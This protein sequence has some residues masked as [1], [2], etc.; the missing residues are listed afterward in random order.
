MLLEQVKIYNNMSDKGIKLEK[1]NFTIEVKYSEKA[2]KDKLIKLTVTK[3]NEIVLS[4][5]EIISMLVGQVNS[6]VLSAAF[7]ET[8][9]VNVVEVMRQLQC[10]LEK[11]LKKGEV[12]NINYIHPYPIEFAIIEEGFK[13]AKISPGTKVTELTVELLEDVKKR[14]TPN[15]VD[16]TKK[17]YQSFNSLDLNHKNM[18]EENTVLGKY[19]V[20]GEIIPFS[21]DGVPQAA[22][23][24]G[25][26]QEVPTVLGEQWVV[27]GRA[28]AVVEEVIDENTREASNSEESAPAVD[29]GSGDMSKPDLAL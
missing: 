28:E 11:D 29:D 15:M 20:I 9:R 10:V 23:E 8:D 22:L 18:S 14:I 6:E 25:S 19:K 4:A 27:D 7:V 1:E 21:E 26:I 12:I 5:D 3:G 2:I 13:I 17:F 24:V 16:F